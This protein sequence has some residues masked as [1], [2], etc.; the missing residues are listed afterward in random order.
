MMGE[1]SSSSEGSKPMGS[2]ASSERK[3][4][5][6]IEA[7]EL[8]D[9]CEEAK[10]ARD[11]DDDSPAAE[12]SSPLEEASHVCVFYPLQ[13]RPFVCALCPLDGFSSR[14]SSKIVS[15]LCEV[16]HVTIENPEE[17]A[18]LQRY[19]D[20]YFKEGALSSSSAGR[21]VVLGCR[22]AGDEALRGRLSSDRIRDVV[23]QQEMERDDSTFSRKC[24]FCRVVVEGRRVDLLNHMFEEH[25]FSVGH[26]YNLV[27]V[28]R[29]LEVLTDKLSLLRCI[30]CD[31]LF[32]NRMV[33]QQH[34]RKKKHFKVSEKNCEYDAFYAVN[35]L[36]P[37][38][39]WK[40]LVEDDEEED[41]A[42][43]G[44][45]GKVEE[46][47]E[48][49]EGRGDEEEEAQESMRSGSLALSERLMTLEKK[50][51]SL[52]G[53]EELTAGDDEAAGWSRSVTCLFC[54]EAFDEPEDCLRHCS[55]AHVGWPDLRETS[56][57]DFY[58]RVRLINFIRRRVL[59]CRCP[60]CDEKVESAESLV[61]HMTAERHFG[62]PPL[63]KF[64]EAQ[65]MIPVEESDPLLTFDYSDES[66]DEGEPRGPTGVPEGHSLSAEERGDGK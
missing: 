49:S 48:E 23:S 47:D 5:E 21:E 60:M 13:F 14:F 30:Y 33:L 15:H 7:A 9:E 18:D 58:G 42:H 36:S 62:I 20:A 56:T 26:P 37:G 35:Y 32:K 65:Y 51:E 24:L 43:S 10:A 8:P 59:D 61:R 63:E 34:M 12:V 29:F 25:G 45:R 22:L 17:V 52:C 3:T 4:Y 46:V 64:S 66:E 40:D 1:S 19:I 54:Q 28:D 2:D 31:K 41:E 6:T 50:A 11:E 16:H 57:L 38:K 39:T 55:G 44:R 53:W 27:F